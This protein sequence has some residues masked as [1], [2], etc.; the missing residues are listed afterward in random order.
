MAEYDPQI[1]VL[2]YR[3]GQ[4]KKTWN[5]IAECA[6]A[7]HVGFNLLKTLLASG[8]PLPS[9]PAVSFDLDPEVPFH[10]ELNADD[11]GRMKPILVAEVE[12]I[13]GEEKR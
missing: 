10:F 2:E 13:I 4:Y 5:G 7:Y 9:D 12:K 1:R 6:R 11:K 3:N 8:S